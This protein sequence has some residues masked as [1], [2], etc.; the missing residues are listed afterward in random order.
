[1]SHKVDE[2]WRI[3][4]LYPEDG[5]VYAACDLETDLDEWVV[6]HE[7][8]L[9]GRWGEVWPQDEEARLA[10]DAALRDI[11]RAAHEPG[12]LIG[13]LHWPLPLPLASRVRVALAAGPPAPVAAWQEAGFDVDEW[14]GSSL[15]PGLK[16]IAERNETIGGVPRHLST[17]AYVFASQEGGVL[18]TVES[19]SREVFDLTL[20][21]MP[22]LLSTLKL[23]LPGGVQFVASEVD[24]MTRSSTDEWKQVSDA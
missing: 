4:G 19:G 23:Y 18:V 13:M 5:W 9:A 6:S 20:A 21:R 3:E 8:K 15:G 11:Y 12:T 7:A 2:T 22:V 17:A 10:N 16:C 1:M 24:G 14:I